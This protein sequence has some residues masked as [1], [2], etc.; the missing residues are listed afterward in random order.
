MDSI[1]VG[2]E[3][4]SH[5]E[6]AE[7]G[8]SDKGSQASLSLQGTLKSRRHLLAW[9]P[10]VWGLVLLLLFYAPGADVVWQA[11][12]FTTQAFAGIQA[13]VQRGLHASQSPYALW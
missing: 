2:A 8:A 5:T 12:R 11:V 13:Y 9:P 6:R 10:S 3:G 1:V 4:V 7:G